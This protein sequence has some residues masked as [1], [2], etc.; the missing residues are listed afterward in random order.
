MDIA[1]AAPVPIALVLSLTPASAPSVASGSLT[2]C[3]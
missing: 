3:T 1:A 2:S